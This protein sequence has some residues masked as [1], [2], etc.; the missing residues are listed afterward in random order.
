MEE[1]K[2]LEVA[3]MQN[4]LKLLY[5]DKFEEEIERIKQQELDS[6]RQLER[7]IENDKKDIRVLKQQKD[8]LE[9]A[10]KAKLRNEESRYSNL[11][12][13]YLQKVASEDKFECEKKE[14]RKT[15]SLCD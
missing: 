9:I 7:V 13:L 1:K 14:L 11:Y 12:S 2:N 10:Y 5:D 4:E 6:R 15:I 3:T 8:Y